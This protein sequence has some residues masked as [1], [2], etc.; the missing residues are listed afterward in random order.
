VNIGDSSA[1]LDYMDEYSLV[2]NDGTILRDSTNPITAANLTLVEPGLT[3]S[4]GGS[5]NIKINTDPPTI[6]SVSTELESGTYGVGQVVDLTVVF[7]YEVAVTGRPFIQLEMSKR[8]LYD[9]ILA[10]PAEGTV[11]YGSPIAGQPA[12]INVEFYLATSMLAG[13]NVTIVLP[14]FTTY[15]KYVG[16]S[17]VIA[18]SPSP[19]LTIATAHPLAR[20]PSHPLTCLRSPAH[21][22]PSTHLTTPFLKVHVGRQTRGRHLFAAVDRR[23][24][25]TLQRLV[26]LRR[27]RAGT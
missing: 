16:P 26:A 15:D 17:R 18:C 22:H 4:L 24:G 11:L 19:P 14:G 3:G 9:G 13:E 21:Y 10:A 25:A 6:S 23:F 27:P 1:D 2:L 12:D 20:S 8:K 7:D 5:K